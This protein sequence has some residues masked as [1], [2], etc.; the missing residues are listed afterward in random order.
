MQFINNLGF[1][2][3]Q[4]LYW[5][6]Y[7]IDEQIQEYY[8]WRFSSYA[9]A[10]E[11]DKTILSLF[12]KST[13]KHD[14]SDIKPYDIAKYRDE[15]FAAGTSYQVLQFDKAIRNFMQYCKRRGYLN[16]EL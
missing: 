11:K 6:R 16:E 14:C 8:D 7:P 1:F 2:M 12:A 15:L 3:F 4:R 13:R 9:L 5:G 10:A